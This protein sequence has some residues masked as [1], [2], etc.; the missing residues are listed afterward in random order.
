MQTRWNFH[1]HSTWCDGKNSVEEMADAA[2]NLGFTALGFSGHAYTPIATDYCMKLEEEEL[3]RQDV[4]CQKEKYKG[5]MQIFLGLEIEGIEK[6]CFPEKQ[7]DYIINSVHYV[8]AHGI[9]YPMDESAETLKRCI[10]E[11]FGG[12]VYKLVDKFFQTS[13]QYACERKPDIIGHFDLLTRYNE[14]G[15]FFDEQSS[16][17]QNIAIEAIREALKSGG[18]FEINSGAI[19]RGIKGRVYPAMFLLK[20]ISRLGGR[21]V[22]SSDAHCTQHLNFAFPLLEELLREAGFRTSMCLTDKGWE[23]RALAIK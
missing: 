12:E 1:T 7:Y 18:I 23:E 9:Y 8:E 15:R 20:E 4:L 5:L 2:Y 21:V 14:C 6:R 16:K 13:A 3:Y 22:I 10:E 17:Y 19:A 11:G